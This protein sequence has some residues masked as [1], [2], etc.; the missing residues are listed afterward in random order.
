MENQ[1]N[2]FLL[3]LDNYPVLMTLPPEQRGWLLT[4]LYV[5]AQRLSREE[6]ADMTQIME[7][8]PQMTEQTQVAFGFMAGNICRDTQK[9]LAQRRSR[10]ERKGQWP[11]SQSSA[12]SQRPGGDWSREREDMERIRRLMEQGRDTLPPSK[13]LRGGTAQETV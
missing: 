13:W 8:F 7:E 10:L 4:A 5:Y 9:W 3:Y 1:K 11:Q 12:A 2:S 6:Q